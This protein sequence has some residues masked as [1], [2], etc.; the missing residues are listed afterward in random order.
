MSQTSASSGLGETPKLRLLVNPAAGRGRAKR[1]FSRIARYFDNRRLDFDYLFSEGPGHLTEL[2]SSFSGS[3]GVIPVACGGDG[4][5]NEIIN[6]LPR[7]SPP[8]GIIPVGTGDDIARNLGIPN[9]IEK[10]CETV[11][12]G[13]IR[14]IDAVDTGSRRYV[15]IGGAGIDSIV[16]RRANEYRIPLP[17]S[18]LYTAAVFS[19]LSSF[20]PFFFSITA[21]DW[22]YQGKVMFVAVANCSSYGGGMRLSPHSKVDDGLLEVC[23]VEEMGRL[24]L[25]RSFP[26][27]FKGNH[28]GNPKFRI[29]PATSV[30]LETDRAA[31]FCADG[32][33]LQPLPVEISVLPGL[34]KFIVPAAAADCSKSSSSRKAPV[35]DN[36]YPR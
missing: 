5:V 22:S 7:P 3:N 14:S 26:A 4:T 32:E 19:S 31:D 29:M 11:V 1:R 21:D 25:L 9:T 33:F 35:K 23:I 17:G 16:T 18:A 15:G 6:G 2:A 13:S 34:V 10:A 27:V 28:L 30:R 36:G 24:E 8:I 20:R 12:S